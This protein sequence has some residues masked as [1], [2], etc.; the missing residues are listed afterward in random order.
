VH[1][2]ATSAT[3][4][5]ICLVCVLGWVGAGVTGASAQGSGLNRVEV[6][7]SVRVR[8]EGSVLI[9]ASLDAWRGNVLVLN[10]SGLSTTWPVAASDLVSL[11]VYTLRTKPE[12]FRHGAI[13]GGV[14]GLF[15]GAALGL[16][17]NSTGV[18]YDPDAAPAQLMT[19]ALAGAGLGFVGGA[20]LGGVYLGRRPGMGWIGI[21]L[22]R[23]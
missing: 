22:P 11:E 4:L 14:S 10:V 8:M 18:T 23:E 2:R 12:S 13:I 16:L 3:R 19:H 9:P 17:L 15:I 1:A 7:D 5:L 20:L 21:T 6:G